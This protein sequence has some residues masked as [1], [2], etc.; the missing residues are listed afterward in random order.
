MYEYDFGDLWEHKITFEKTVRVDKNR[1]Y[2]TC[3][4]GQNAG[5]PEDCGGP[6]AY[7]NARNF[8]SRRKGKKARAPRGRVSVFEKE[9][10]RENYRSFDPDEFDRDEVNQQLAE[11]FKGK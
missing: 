11:L 6:D 1:N 3:T 9:F 5:P 7:M 8:L 10:Y 4:A 2:P